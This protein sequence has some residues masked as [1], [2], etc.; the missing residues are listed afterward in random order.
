MTGDG[1]GADLGKNIT[2]SVDPTNENQISNTQINKKK[3]KTETNNKDQRNKIIE[4][5]AV[6][7]QQSTSSAKVA[8]ND[9]C[10]KRV[11]LRVPSPSGANKIH[12]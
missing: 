11:L 12:K 7:P 8:G 9:T 6:D 3:V 4:I 5:E 1:T 10:A 2:L